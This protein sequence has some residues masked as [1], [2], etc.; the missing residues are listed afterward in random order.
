MTAGL[1][2]RVRGGDRVPGGRVG[3]AV[4]ATL[5]LAAAPAL[6][7]E[8][9]D[10]TGPF[11][12]CPGV[13]PWASAAWIAGDYGTRISQG[14]L[15]FEFADM[16]GHPAP[17]AEAALQDILRGVPRDRNGNPPEAL[18][19]DGFDTEALQVARVVFR[20]EGSGGAALYAMMIARGGDGLLRLML[21][22]YPEVPLAAFDRATRDLAGLVAL[23]AER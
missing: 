14:G 11:V 15:I 7:Q 20:L 8:C 5:A 19:R 18:I 3:R 21:T 13:T 1:F 16:T 9:R 10:L 2:N 12:L 6:A 4:A 17:T 23:S 22:A